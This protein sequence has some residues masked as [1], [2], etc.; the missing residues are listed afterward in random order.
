MAFDGLVS[1]SLEEKEKLKEPELMSP[2]KFRPLT[3][4]FEF[5]PQLM[6]YC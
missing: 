1:S 3:V 4:V 6:K 2:M 5:D